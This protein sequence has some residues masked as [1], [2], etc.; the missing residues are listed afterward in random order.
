ML[1]AQPFIAF[2][3]FVAA[4]PW[5]W[6]NPVGRTWRL[7]AFRS[8]EMDAQTS[9]W[10]NAL[11]ESPFEALARFGY[12]LTYTHSTSQKALQQVYDW[13]GFER[14]A[15][16]FD[17]V[18]AAAGVAILVW[19]LGR[20]GLWTPRAL[21]TI[22]VFGELALLAIGMKADFYRYHLPVVMIVSVPLAVAVGALWDIATARR[23]VR[24]EANDPVLEGAQ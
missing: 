20:Y 16:G 21:V 2:A 18:L 19:G 5:L 13:L 3:S 8:S 9:A 10:P 11:T 6:E 24:R 17:L 4:Y 7:F 12:K 22:L 15:V 1:I 14:T 23:M